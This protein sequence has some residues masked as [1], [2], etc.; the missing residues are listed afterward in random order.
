MNVNICRKTYAELMQYLHNTYDQ[1][2]IR[3]FGSANYP[4]QHPQIRILPPAPQNPSG[5]TGPKRMFRVASTGLYCREVKLSSPWS[6]L[7]CHWIRSHCPRASWRGHVMRR[8]WLQ[9]CSGLCMYISTDC[10]ML[11]KMQDNIF[12][13]FCFKCYFPCASQIII[14]VWCYFPSV[15]SGLV[16]LL[17]NFV[18]YTWLEC[19]LLTLVTGSLWN[20]E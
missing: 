6:V 7:T 18:K 2:N 19:R 17:A 5:R 15:R 9:Y 16:Q 20:I 1:R 8:R 14:Y 13:T 10:D 3:S 11:V 12:F 4:L